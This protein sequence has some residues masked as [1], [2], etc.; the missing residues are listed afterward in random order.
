LGYLHGCNESNVSRFVRVAAAT[1]LQNISEL[2]KRTWAFS[3]AFDSSTIE[4]TS[5]FDV[6]VRFATDAELHCFNMLAFPLHGSHT[7]QL[8]FDVFEQAMDAIIPGWEDCLLLACSDGG[9]NML[10]RARGIVTRIAERSNAAGPTLIRFW[11][12]AHQFDLVVSEVVQ[13]CCDENWYSTLT[14]LIGYLRRQIN[15]VNEMGSKCPKVAVTRWVSLGKV[16]PW[17]AKHRT[18]V[19][20]YL[21]EKNPACKPTVFWWI[22]LHALGCA[23]DEINSLF[24]Y[25]Q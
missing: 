11:R 1:C 19:I 20:L 7:G 9:R 6:R 25:L 12:G 23:T 13:A 22:S 3:V 18:R 24:M 14:A 16:L 10:G 8:I 21:D 5:C 4:A 17:L 15:L 2:L